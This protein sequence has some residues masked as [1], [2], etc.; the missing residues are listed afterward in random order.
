M[1]NKKK[2]FYFS[3]QKAKTAIFSRRNGYQGKI[4]LGYSIRIRF[5]GYDLI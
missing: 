2:L 4:I 1:A 3:I 5:L